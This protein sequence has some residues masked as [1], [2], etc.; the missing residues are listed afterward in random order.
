MFEEEKPA[1][2]MFCTTN[3]VLAILLH[4]VFFFFC[5]LVVQ[6]LRTKETVIP[7]DL[8]LVLHENLDGV[9]NEPPPV[10]P[11][12]PAP[13]KPEPP[14][15]A[16]PPPEPPKPETKVDAVVK[17]PKEK[18]KEAEKPKEKPKPKETLEERIARMRSQAKVVNEKP[19]PQ[20][21]P[22]NNGRTGKKTLSD[23]EIKKL[24]NMGYKPG[25]TEQL[26]ANEEQRC[27]S[28]IYRAFY[29]RW[30]SPNYSPSLRE[31]KLRVYFDAGGRVVNW[32]LVQSSGDAAADATV[33][34]AAQLVKYVP[35]L[36][37]SFLR[38]NKSV[39]VSFKVKPQ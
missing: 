1:P 17:T 31:M 24:L 15:P 32:S 16:T 4:L 6:P 25:A 14:K 34:K 21:K 7:M 11:P 18:P 33:R 30:D 9:D 39:V 26:A 38:A 19:R 36:S 20:P 12:E 23:A 10:K 28:L 5:W 8:T 13:P 27:L 35:G 29:D 22:Q 3:I 2:K 37:D